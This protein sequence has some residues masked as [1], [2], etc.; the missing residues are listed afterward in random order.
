M[1]TSRAG[2]SAL[3]LL[4]AIAVL[5]SETIEYAVIGAMAAA[6]HGSLRATTDADALLSV[7]VAKLKNLSHA[8]KQAGFSTE[9]RRGDADDPIPAMLMV[10]DAHGNRVDLLAG[11]RGLDPQVFARAVEVPF[12]GDTLRVVG[13]EDFIAM[14]CFAGGPQ[15]IEDARL[16]LN[17]APGPL[18]LDLLRRVARGFGRA[19]ADVLEQVLAR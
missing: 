8:F 1:R 18:D 12:S 16:A 19:A 11:L 7:T 13:R 9:L 10:S 6:I 3:L 4:D 14:K 15:D 17:S 5:R 2:Q